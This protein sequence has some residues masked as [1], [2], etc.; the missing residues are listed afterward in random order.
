MDLIELANK[1]NV[2]KGEKRHNYIKYYEQYFKD[3]RLDNLNIL[4]IGIYEGM[5]LLMWDEYFINST[6]HGLDIDDELFCKELKNNQRIKTYLADQRQHDQLDIFFR[7][8]KFDI[9]IDDGSHRAGDQ[10]GSFEY[11]LPKMNN[12]G[13][14][15]IEDIHTAYDTKRDKWLGKNDYFLEY[16]KYLIDKV[17]QFG[18]SDKN[19]YCN[20]ET[21][22]KTDIYE[23]KIKSI[24]FYKS[25]V[26]F[27]IR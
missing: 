2:D 15:I 8:E 14:Y 26:I 13:L 10:E 19:G 3:R 25:I 23:E 1:Y 16:C 4:E 27:L 5:S 9:V 18:R 12:N 11:F 17:N 6:I 7:D 22:E 21:V 20:D 24:H